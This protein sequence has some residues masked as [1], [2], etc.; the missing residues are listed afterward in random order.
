M[1]CSP[2]PS[3][4]SAIRVDNEIATEFGSSGMTPTRGVMRTAARVQV[5]GTK[6]VVST[7]PR[8]PARMPAAFA[9]SALSSVPT[10]GRSYPRWRLGP[11]SSGSRGTG[12]SR[13][14]VRREPAALGIRPLGAADEAEILFR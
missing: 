7:S 5:N 10:G 9:G 8:A 1:I 11:W 14:R 4:M 3:A 6:V 12:V 13:E 2:D